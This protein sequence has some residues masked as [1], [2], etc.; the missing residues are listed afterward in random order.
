[1]I[2]PRL[3]FSGKYPVFGYWIAALLFWASANPVNAG[4]VYY[5]MVFASQQIP[6]RPN[7]AHSF[8]TFVHATWEGPEPC[9]QSPTLE[10]HTISWLPA[11]LIVRTGALFPEC[12]HNFDLYET[13][14]YVYQNDERVS[15]WGP[16][17]IEKELYDRA[18]RQIALLESAQVLYKADD[19]GRKSNRVSNCIHAVSSVAE[20]YRLRIAEPGFGQTASFAITKHFR[21]WII[22]QDQVH[23][24]IGS[25]LDLDKYPIVYRDWTPPRSG[26]LII[27]PIYRLLGSEK[28]LKA[29]YGPPR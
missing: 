1:M 16:Y 2:A 22:D 26:G 5:V 11:N 12:G 29:T 28:N 7:Y 27:G 3:W 17:Q 15:M 4:E 23:A 13:L 6:P 25:A 18:M 19:V 20:G 24:W 9:P 14:R 10:A 21:P 8:A